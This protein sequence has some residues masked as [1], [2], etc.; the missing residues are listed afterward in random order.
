[1]KL[2]DLKK[3]KAVCN[4]LESEPNWKEVVTEMHYQAIDFEVDGVR[5][6]DEI[7]Q[8]ELR[9]DPYTLGCFN[10]SFLAEVTGLPIKSFEALQK[11][12]CYEE[13]GE[14]ILIMNKL[15]DFQQEYS[16]LDGYGVHFN[17]Y[18]GSED[19]I[20]IEGSEYLIFDNRG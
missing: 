7:M 5:F 13:I 8:E 20:A 16:S 3:I 14:H 17:S 4:E 15:E 10:P 11:A 19:F 6:I 18:D 12:E 1:M 9:S 2:S